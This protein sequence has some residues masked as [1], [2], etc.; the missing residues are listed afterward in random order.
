M[1]SVPLN[2]RIYDQILV[3][4]LNFT[5]DTAE[6]HKEGIELLSKLMMIHREFTEEAGEFQDMFGEYMEDTF[7]TNQWAGQFLT[8]MNVVKLMSMINI[9]DN[10]EELMGEPKKICD[11]C[12]GTGRFMLGVAEQYAKVVKCFN[13]LFVNVDVDKR[14]FTYCTMNAILNAIPSIHIWGNSLKVEVFDA[15]A[16]LPGYLQPWMKVPKEKA[17]EMIVM[18]LVKSAEMK[19]QEVS[20]LMIV[21][22]IATGAETIDAEVVEE[23]GDVEPEIVDPKIVLEP[24]E[25]LMMPVRVSSK[26]V[27]QLTFDGW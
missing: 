26:K 14:A 19:K 15:F 17:K 25:E 1:N 5:P 22:P 6:Q 10:P 2:E 13:F 20:P 4:A 24:D 21:A 8:P 23:P 12:C 7:N 27:I 18:A 3:G 9:R 16:V 11:P